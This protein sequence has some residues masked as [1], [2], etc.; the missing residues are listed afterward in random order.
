M[1]DLGINDGSVVKVL[2][3]LCVG[4]KRMFNRI[5]GD[6]NTDQEQPFILSTQQVFL[7]RFCWYS[8]ARK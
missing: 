7:L 3:I 2:V 6:R 5:G 4:K 8:T 1:V